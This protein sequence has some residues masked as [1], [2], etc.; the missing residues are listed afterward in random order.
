MEKTLKRKRG[1]VERS[2]KARI[3]KKKRQELAIEKNPSLRDELRVGTRPGQPNVE[4]NQPLL[5]KTIIALAMH[6]S[7]SHEKRQ[8][9]V[10]RTI[11]TLDELTD[12]LNKDGFNISRSGVYLRLLPRRSASIEG[13]RHV[14]TVPVKLIRAQND[15]HAQHVDGPFCTATIRYLEEL[16]SFLGPQEVCFISQDDKCRVPIGLTAANKQSPLLMHVEYRVSLPD[17]DLV[18]AEKHKL[19]PSV[20]AGIQIHPNG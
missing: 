16:A 20:Y 7:A 4:E 10:Y 2:Q 19:I 15:H 18:V 5:L 12:Q 17:H 13:Q 6:G 11:K 14:V 9:D 1:E 3:A 8:S